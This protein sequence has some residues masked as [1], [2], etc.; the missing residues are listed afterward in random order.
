[1]ATVALVSIPIEFSPIS[2][3]SLSRIWSQSGIL[4]KQSMSLLE[5]VALAI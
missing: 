3:V 5:L 4:D 1:M 2:A